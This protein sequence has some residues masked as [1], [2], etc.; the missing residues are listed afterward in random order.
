MVNIVI[1]CLSSSLSSPLPASFTLYTLCL[2]CSPSRSVCLPTL[3]AHFSLIL[4]QLSEFFRYFFFLSSRLR[5]LVNLTVGSTKMAKFCS[6][7]N[8]ALLMHLLYQT[9][10]S[11]VRK[12]IFSQFKTRI[13]YSHNNRQP[14][15]TGGNVA[16]SC[17][18][19]LAQAL[20]ERRA[21]V[22]CKRR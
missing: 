8:G 9:L 15:V 2:S 3:D 22:D 20:R 21:D 12:Q 7:G 1:S 6:Y 19:V 4:I 18:C 17:V 16:H 13:L 11:V 5:V 14:T 10:A